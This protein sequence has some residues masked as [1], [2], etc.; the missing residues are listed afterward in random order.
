MKGERFHALLDCLVFFFNV[1]VG[2]RRKGGGSITCSCLL[3]FFFKLRKKM[4]E[5][6]AEFRGKMDL[7]MKAIEER[8]PEEAEC[9]RPDQG[10]RILHAVNAGAAGQ[11]PRLAF[12]TASSTS[13][14]SQLL[15]PGRLAVSVVI[16]AFAADQA[17]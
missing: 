10:K 5:R 4:E 8:G 3:S 16:T 13:L 2:E 11:L 17:D 7:D 14:L 12:A 9:G 15:G 6:K 1:T